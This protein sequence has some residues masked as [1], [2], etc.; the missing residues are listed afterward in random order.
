M[1][2]V[3]AF[4]SFRLASTASCSCWCLTKQVGWVLANPRA[5]NAYKSSN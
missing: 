4:L 1:D 2:G 3:L 5:T